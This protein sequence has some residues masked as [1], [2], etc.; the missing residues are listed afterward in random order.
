MTTLVAPAEFPDGP[1]LFGLSPQVAHLNHG[2]FGAVPGPV[3]RAHRRLLAEADADPDAFFL[4][5][6][7]RLA[8]ARSRVADHLGADPEGIA[9][10]TNATEAAHLVMD[11]LRLDPDDEVLVTDHGYG[12]VVGAA[13]CRARL[14]TVALDPAL[15]CPTRTRYT[16]RCSPP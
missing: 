1:S 7:D 9:F 13:A 2:S 11:A 3:A 14:N 15:P 10:V 4:A 5:I 6:P 12:T 8:A 16:E